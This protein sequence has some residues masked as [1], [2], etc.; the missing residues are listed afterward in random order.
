MRILRFSQ[1]AFRTEAITI[2]IRP[3]VKA[4][5]ILIQERFDQLWSSQVLNYLLNRKNH[6]Y[7]IAFL[8]DKT[9]YRFSTLPPNHSDFEVFS[10]KIWTRF[11]R[12]GAVQIRFCQTSRQYAGFRWVLTPFGT[13]SDAYR[14]FYDPLTGVQ[15]KSHTCNAPY[16]QHLALE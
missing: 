11:S 14:T 15:A 7:F 9:L 12:P 13:E 16:A 2:Y 4:E 1:E 3:L 6:E 8:S 5:I 10:R